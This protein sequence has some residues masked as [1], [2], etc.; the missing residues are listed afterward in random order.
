MRFLF[1]DRILTLD[2]GMQIIGLKHVTHDDYYLSYD[3]QGRTCFT[4][5]LVGETLGQLAAWRVMLH[6]DFRK[7]PV[8]GIVAKAI[9]SRPVYIGET[10]RLEAYIDSLDDVAVQYHAVAYV[11]TNEVFRLE[12]AVGPLLPMDQF[13][14]PA[15]A[16][17]QFNEIYRPGQWL[18][19]MACSSAK[20]IIHSQINDRKPALGAGMLFD[21]IITHDPCVS[22]VAEKALTRAAAYFD[23][24]FPH[25]PVLPLSIL[26]ECTLNLVRMF[27]ADFPSK[28]IIHTVRRIK[29]SDFVLPGSILIAKLSIKQHTLEMLAVIARIEVEGKRVCTFEIQALSADI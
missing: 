22:C 18:E 20:Q 11:D 17:Q 16:R 3:E 28:Y 7:R 27:I 1:V 23:D 14:D 29:M 12:G 19:S 25:K 6:H 4:T 8:A 10:I 9:L 15:I 26:L 24:H 5:S 21:H 13:I 2:H